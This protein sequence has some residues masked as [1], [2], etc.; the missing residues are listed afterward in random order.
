MAGIPWQGAYRPL[1]MM[2]S[3][4]RQQPFRIWLAAFLLLVMFA[5][6]LTS[7]VTESPTFDEQGF[8]V[9]G[10]AYLRG[11]DNGGSR[12]IRVGHPLGLNAVNGFL[13]AMDSDVRLPSN[14][15]SW[16][17]T[18]FHRPAELFLWEIGN[19]VGRIMLLGRLPTLWLGLLMAAISARWASQLTRNSRNPDH[20]PKTRRKSSWPAYGGLITLAMLALDPNILAH[21][22]LATT[23]LG[24]AA[25]AILAGYTLWLFLKRPGWG[26]AVLAG[27]SLGLLQNTKFTALLFL[28]LFGIVILVGAWQRIRMRTTKR[29]HFLVMIFLVYPV[30]AFLALWATNGFQTGPLPEPLPVLGELG[31]GTVPLSEHLDQLLDI[32]N[33]LQVSTPAFLLGEYSDVGW[34]YYFPVA[35]VLKTPLPTIL[36]MAWGVIRI[37]T[38]RSFFSIL[39]R[40][41]LLIPPLGYLAIALTSD[42]NLGYRHLLPML[43][44]LFVFTG[45]AMGQMFTRMPAGNLNPWTR[46][47]RI[48]ALTLL[49]WLAVVSIW[50][51][52]H[53]LAF[54]N[55]LAGGPDHG[56]RALVDSNLDWGQDLSNLKL[57]LDEHNEHPVWLSYFGEGR[58][59]YYGIRY[60]GLDSFPP[61][62]MNPE[63]RPFYPWDPAPGLYA[64]S[65]TNLQGVHFADH[66]QFAYFR[67]RTPQAKVGYSIFLYDQPAHGQPVDL[68]L[69]NLQVDELE[70]DDFARLATNDVALRWFD[71]NQAVVLPTRDRPVWLALANSVSLNPSLDPFIE[72]VPSTMTGA[73]NYTLTEVRPRYP[74]FPNEPLPLVH[75]GSQISFIGS[76][77]IETDSNGVTLATAWRQ[78][79]APQ[80]VKIFIHLL[81]E[82]DEIVAQWDGLDAAWDGWLEG[83]TLIQIHELNWPDATP[84]GT[85][86]LVAGL[87]HPDTIQR[88]RSDS[89]SDVIE[90]AEISQP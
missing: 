27:A 86:R 74:E 70:P 83:D 47:R 3:N 46:R 50:M 45:G 49:T 17:S 16:Q 25:A 7:M 55:V 80:P 59:E 12:R 26:L 75:N 4:I 35:F 78:D 11:E 2:S 42:I 66:D 8:L 81:D 39:D 71:A 41:A 14:D 21:M 34:W 68:L 62:L 6:A 40:V 57:W 36:L 56:W 28:P 30:S 20:N 61:R 73:D 63:T 44:F 23:D 87:Y 84:A 48:M 69:G 19:D 37:A 9:R 13:L 76:S 89:G 90:L 79:G 64:I 22:R 54:F 88:W 18:S 38:K 67:E 51:Y 53:Y 15:P 24:L 77:T 60:K 1:F 82:Q 43:P 31:G 52:P 29:Q 5:L 72:A 65:V 85:Y 32:G 58:P 33:R 10:V